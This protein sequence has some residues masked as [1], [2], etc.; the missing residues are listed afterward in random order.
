MDKNGDIGERVMEL[1]TNKRVH[2]PDKTLIWYR[3]KSHKVRKSDG[4]TE[5]LRDLAI[6]EWTYELEWREGGDTESLK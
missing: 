6:Q 5:H 1:I 2:R 3:A 4:S